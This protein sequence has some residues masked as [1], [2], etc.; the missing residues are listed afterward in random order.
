MKILVAEDDLISRKLITGTLENFGHQVTVCN[1]GQAAWEVYLQEPH[2]VVVS[3]WLMPRLDGLDFCRQIRS[4]PDME[5]TYFI[6]LTANV[7][8]G[9]YREA[10]D[11]G[12][13]DFLT[14]PLDRDQIWTRLRVAQRILQYTQQ[15]SQLES[16]LPICSYCKKV[17]NEEDYWE[18]VESYIGERTGTVFSHGVCPGCYESVV[19]PQLESIKN[20]KFNDE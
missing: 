4:K 18:Q 19:K 2:R 13:D 17:R 16:M 7:Q 9:S 10:M 15:I 8:S 12:V 1:D 11:A 5:Y 6:L 20:F 14:K 3:D